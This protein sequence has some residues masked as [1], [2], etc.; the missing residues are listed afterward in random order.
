MVIWKK[1]GA[2]EKNYVT[3]PKNYGTLIYYGKSYDT[4]RVTRFILTGNE[5]LFGAFTLLTW[6]VWDSI[7]EIWSLSQT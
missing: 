4:T 6:F 3:I 5:A 1:Y 7:N 2:T